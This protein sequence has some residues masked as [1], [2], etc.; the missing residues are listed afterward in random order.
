MGLMPPKARTRPAAAK[1]RNREEDNLLGA[2]F[3]VAKHRRL[4]AF[5]PLPAQFS[6]GRHVTATQGDTGW[7]DAVFAG[8]GGHI[9]REFKATKGPVKP[10]QKRWIDT[11]AA[12]GADVAVWRPGDLLSGRIERELRAIAKPRRTLAAPG[13]VS[14]DAIDAEAF[15]AALERIREADPTSPAARIATDVLRRHAAREVAD[16]G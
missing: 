12:G 6:D 15:R 10:E 13:G 5:H 9:I 11:L 3:D 16:R 2:A 8:P 1:P 7:P 14:A 4:L